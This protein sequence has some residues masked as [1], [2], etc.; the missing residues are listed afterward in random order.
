MLAKA[1]AHHTTGWLPYHHNAMFISNKDVF[2][3]VLTL[4]STL[5]NTNLFTVC[6]YSCLHPCR[7]LWVCPEVFGWRPPDGARRLQAG[8][9]KR[10]GHHLYW[11]NWRHSNKAFWCSDRRWDTAA[12]MLTKCWRRNR[13]CC[14]F[15]SLFLFLSCYPN[16]LSCSLYF[17]CSWQ[18]GAENLTGAAQ[19]N[20]RLWPERQRQGDLRLNESVE[21]LDLPVL[22]TLLPLSKNRLSWLSCLED[23]YYWNLSQN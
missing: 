18:G 1:V 3:F 21:E 6:Y 19:S 2:F 20:G 13:L 8:K 9:G 5:K 23:S 17:R 14:V 15:L 7:G 12:C 4:T 16:K 11:W 10:P 22:A